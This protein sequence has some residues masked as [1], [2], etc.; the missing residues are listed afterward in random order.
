MIVCMRRNKLIVI[1][2]ALILCFFKVSIAFAQAPDISY[3]I[4]PGYTVNL[5]ITALKPTNGGGAV[6]NSGYGSVTTLAGSGSQGSANGP[7]NSASFY[8]PTGLAADKNGNIYIADEGNSLIRKISADG[9][10]VIF[11]GSGSAAFA[12]G[13][14]TAASFYKPFGL[15]VDGAGNVYVADSNNKRI[16]KITP[17]GVVTTVA[18][19]GN[20]GSDN[21][22]GTA[23]TFNQPTAI[24][25]DNAGNL[26]VTDS[27]N[28]LIRKITP[29]GV[30]TTLAG[31]GIA[32]RFD[33][34]GTSALFNGPFGIAVDASGNIYVAD[35]YNSLIRKITFA[36][37][38]STFAGGTTFGHAD[39]TGR[40]ASFHD[41]IGLTIDANGNL[42]VADTQNNSIRKITPMGVVSTVS[43]NNG[44]GSVNGDPASATFNTPYAVAVDADGNLYAGDT[45]NNLV[46]KIIANG[47]TIDKQLP[48]GLTFDPATGKITGTPTTPSP[49][50]VYTVTA[51]NAGGSN[52]TTL[53]IEVKDNAVPNAPDADPPIISYETPKTYNINQTITPLVPTSSGSPVP[54]EEFGQ[55]LTLS[56]SGDNGSSNGDA[57][58]SSFSNPSGVAVDAAGNTYV[59]DSDNNIIR[60]IS[61][62]GVTTTF[63]GSGSPGF[64]D[65]NGAVAS[66]QGPGGIVIDAFG[67]LYVADSKNHRIRK[68]TPAG[69]VSTLAGKFTGAGDGTGTA[70]SFNTPQGIAIDA[71]GNLYVADTF[72]NLIRKISPAGDVITLAGSGSPGNANGTGTAASFNSPQNLTVDAAGNVYVTDLGNNVIRKITPLGDVSTYAGNGSPGGTNGPALL[73]SFNKPSG[74]VA[75]DIGD[76]FVSDFG[77]NLI[78]MIDPSGNVITLAGDGSRGSLNN[79]GTVASFDS[80]K[81]LA[82]D[83]AGKLYIADSFNNDIRTAYIVGY[84]IDKPVPSG[85]IFNNATG[86]ISGKPDKVSP[87][88]SYTI[89]A[90][91]IHGS[92]T[93][94]V[95]IKVIDSQTITFLPIPDKTVCDID[96]DPG[97]KSNSPITY[98]SSDLAV[99]IIIANKVHITGAGPTTITASDGTS[100]YPQTLTVIAGVTPSVT[101]SP[102]TFDE[103][104]GVAVTYTATPVNGGDTPHFQWKVNGL[105]SGSDSPDFISSNLNNNDK[106]TCILT[107]SIAC[108]TSPAATSNEAVFTLDPPV[109]TSVTITSSSLNGP[110]CAGTEIIFTA[111]PVSPDIKP[112]Y[113]WQVNGNNAGTDSSAFSSA[114]LA[115]GDVVTCILTSTG[116]CLINPST[117]SNAITVKL[118]PNSQCVIVIPNAFT[119]NGDGINDLWNISALQGYPNCSL[120]IFT[121]YGSLIFKSTGYVKA[122][123]GTYNGSALPV[124]TYYYIL[125][126]KNGKKTMSGA[127]TIL[128]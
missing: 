48:P 20:T 77:G 92:S 57:L 69:D 118:N 23:A 83:P 5:P 54:V 128:R 6:P 87:L 63:A 44:P 102:G 60:K 45:N 65:G 7:G 34:T 40:A 94:T 28:N 16:R 8:R 99:A 127:V 11:A 120:T 84:R 97:A 37:V 52:S 47:Y 116:K 81:G 88:T 38:V 89:T 32:G 117:S 125:D 90:Y 112:G 71:A 123:D 68:I 124:G 100:T 36:G 82:L 58:T 19:N 96:F 49:L 73:A 72:N 12:D 15:T 110:V 109:T 29:A 22:T 17:E 98:T 66:F 39:G 114:T 62:T 13:T 21:G 108:T 4:H 95:E 126:I 30:V 41:P 25:I 91:N 59:A 61:P 18:G 56:G 78:R 14:G 103:C 26:Y 75:D 107:S 35:S 93:F 113:Q 43:V 105:N 46:R 9:H 67:N 70:A 50:T 86:V 53:T 104:S 121:R 31:S 80:P 33:G 1:I 79:T 76:L 74:I 101:I 85:L 119:P 27:G 55:T 122:W 42:Y 115:D 2:Y 10:V 3:P 106:I 51:Y 64:A 111:T 24:A